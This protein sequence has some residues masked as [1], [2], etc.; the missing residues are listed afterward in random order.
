LP[1]EIKYP[2]ITNK[3]H[4]GAV[5]TSRLLPTQEISRLLT[6]QISQA[7]D[8]QSQIIDLAEL[9]ISQEIETQQTPQI[10]HKPT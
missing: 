6:Q 10:I 9:N 4:S 5:Y 1:E 2:D 3:T 7:I 8:G